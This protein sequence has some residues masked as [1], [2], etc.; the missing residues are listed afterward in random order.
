[1]EMP[2]C[3]LDINPTKHAWD[4]LEDVLCKEFTLPEPCKNRKVLSERRMIIPQKDSSLV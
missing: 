1:M 4:V 2:T 3:T